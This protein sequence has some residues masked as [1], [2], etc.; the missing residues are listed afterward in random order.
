M[1]QHIAYIA[2]KAM[3]QHIACIEL[4]ESHNMLLFWS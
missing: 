2:R 3:E 1:E 4:D